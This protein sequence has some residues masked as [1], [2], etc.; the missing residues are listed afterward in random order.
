MTGLFGEAETE[1]KEHIS[2][3]DCSEQMLNVMKLRFCER[4]LGTEQLTLAVY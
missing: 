2:K 4:S 1:A 3:T